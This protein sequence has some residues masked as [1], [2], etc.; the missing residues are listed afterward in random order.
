MERQRLLQ[1]AGE[2]G[3]LLAEQIPT[4]TA[5]PGDSFRK[6][7]ARIFETPALAPAPFVEPL[8][9]IDSALDASQRDAV[10]R[11]L[12][13][14]DLL[15][16]QGLPGTGKTRV[17]AEILAQSVRNRK[18]VLFLAQSGSAVDAA[19][20]QL[21]EAT[22]DAG[23]R[24][25][26][27]DEPAESLPPRVARM[28]YKKSQEILRAESIERAATKERTLEEECRQAREQM[29][30][31]P[32]LVELAERHFQR[33]AEQEMLG[34]RNEAIET[35][36]ANDVESPQKSTAPLPFTDQLRQAEQI[37]NDRLA[38]WKL[39]SIELQ[40]QRGQCEIELHQ[41]LE[42]RELLR[43][44]EDACHSSRFWS[45]S[46]WK[47]RFNKSLPV[48]LAEV[49][50]D[51][52]SREK[53]VEEI[54]ARADELGAELARIETAWA[55]DKRK[56]I[57]AEV[58]RRR[59]EIDERAAVLAHVAAEEA[60]QFQRLGATV[61][62]TPVFDFD[63]VRDAHEKA[64]VHLR[65]LE[66]DRSL[67]RRWREFVETD[68]EEI[69]GRSRN[70]VQFVAGP[71]SALF[72]DPWFVGAEQR[73]AFDL[74]I[75]DEAHLL[76]E[77]D[78]MTAAKR[79][80]RWV[81]VG[82]PAQPA[83]A[84]ARSRPPSAGPPRKPRSIPDLF[85]RLWDQLHHETWTTE[86]GRLCCR[87]HPVVAAERRTLEKETVADRAEIE[88]RILNPRSGEPILAEV[89]FPPSMRLAEAKEYLFREMGEIPCISRIR[90][91]RWVLN[92]DGII[93]RLNSIPDMPMPSRSVDLG[94]GIAMLADDA[95]PCL[96]QSEIALR[97]G[98]EGGWDRARA[99]AWV[100]Q[101][102]LMR[103]SGRACRLETNHRQSPA[104][105][106]WLNEAAFS[107]CRYAVDGATESAVQ[108]EPVPRR[109]PA[110]GQRRGGAGFEIDLGDPRQREL[111]PTDLASRLPARGCVNLPEAQAISEF[112]QRSSFG[113][114]AAVTAAYPA[115]TALLRL[116]CAKGVRIVEPSML[117]DMEC[118]VLILGLTRSHVSRAVTYG[119]DPA[120]VPLALTRPSSRLIVFGDP[121]TLARRAQW[122]G[123]VDHLDDVAG[124]RERR[125]VNA[126]LRLLPLRSTQHSRHPEGIKV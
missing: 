9:P 22:L 43:P 28:T 35:D 21:P 126:L 75:I 102:L 55:D 14:P 101:H 83:P 84:L 6:V 53:V 73:A 41:A 37:H 52:E 24:C 59:V 96:S 5:A 36:V 125:W 70:S 47:A 56:L 67:A 19:L 65:Q 69:A 106:A 27:K 94:P 81:L 51:V 23:I 31:W 45:V 121:G 120:E 110:G 2:Q 114:A 92:P 34:R 90:S 40:K 74:L 104:L 10:A 66:R 109:T 124:E 68:A 25:L 119:D 87:L 113:A 122:E 46:F 58:M 44:M 54:A 13:A 89:L 85:G 50:A 108:F 91:A 77:R 48:Q 49:Q 116:I 63:A 105:A 99:E 33:G 18:K 16:I 20:R 80:R 12:Q 88:L 123:A 7:L 98:V 15:L 72:A 112:L 97:F 30:V 76:F 3:Y 57:E 60:E 95:S 42:R 17:I 29:S 62:L 4:F 64:A 107:G 8:E 61:G 117:G 78:L 32:Q 111:L 118:D 1:L 100:H 39:E 26:G 115:Q 38:A 11:A 103:D 79:A 82:E 71:L 93:F 86:G